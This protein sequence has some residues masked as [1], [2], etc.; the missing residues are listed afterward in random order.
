MR[1]KILAFVFAA[2][3]LMAMAVPL[4]GGIGTAQAVGLHQH[5]LG[6]PGATGVKI[7]RGLCTADAHGQH[8]TAFHSFHGNVHQGAFAGVNPNTISTTSC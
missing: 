8:D 6:T 1:K 2:A 4:F 3:V 5:M 7:G